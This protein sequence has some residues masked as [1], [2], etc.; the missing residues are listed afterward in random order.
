MGA[1]LAQAGEAR[2]LPRFLLLQGE[3]AL[4]LGQTGAVAAALSDLEQMLARSEAREEGWYLPELFR[5]RGELLLIREGAAGAA[6][7]EHAF[8]RSLE[9]AREQGALAWE[10]RAAASL[11]R[12]WRDHGRPR[13]AVTLLRAVHARFSEGADTADVAD[14]AR[15]LDALA[16]A[17]GPRLDETA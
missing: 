12:L 5:I 6:A 16:G 15:L 8:R 9:Q 17:D 1:A 4:Y 14:A 10:L 7:A 3:Q 13:E 11:A 2:F